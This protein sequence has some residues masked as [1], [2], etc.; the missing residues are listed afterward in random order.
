M[1]KSALNKSNAAYRLKEARKNLN[2]TQ[3]QLGER[4]GL[5]WYQIKDLEGGRVKLTL[6]LVKLFY[7]EFDINP[8]W[9][10][11]GKGGM[12]TRKEEKFNQYDRE[13]QLILNELES[14]PA[15]K[16]TFI[17]FIEA[18]KGNKQAFEDIRNIIKGL[19]IIFE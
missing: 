17:K 8:D 15:L 13:T 6:L 11:N 10:L 18:K 12:F 9:L 4:A 1:N 7:Y 5:S 19:Q 2:L 16:N 14:S 3:K